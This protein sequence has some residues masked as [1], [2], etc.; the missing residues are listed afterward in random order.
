MVELFKNYD[1]LEDV[2]LEYALTAVTKLT[3]VRKK[4]IK[5]RVAY[6]G[7]DIAPQYKLES[8][9]DEQK[10]YSCERALR[11]PF[12]PKGYIKRNFFVKDAL[13]LDFFRFFIVRGAKSAFS[14]SLSFLKTTDVKV[15][16][17]SSFLSLRKKKIV[18][19]TRPLW[20]E[21][22]GATLRTQ[23]IRRVR[24]K[25]PPQQK[26]SDPVYTLNER[27]ATNSFSETL[28][29]LENRDY[30]QISESFRNFYLGSRWEEYKSFPIEIPRLLAL[31]S[32]KPV[33]FKILDKKFSSK[34]EKTGKLLVSTLIQYHSLFFS[35]NK[36]A[37][38][39]AIASLVKTKNIRAFR[40]DLKFFRIFDKDLLNYQKG[41]KKALNFKISP[42][43]LTKFYSSRK[44]AKLRRIGLI[45]AYKKNYD[46]LFQGNR[47]FNNLGNPSKQ[48]LLFFTR[49]GAP[50]KANVIPRDLGIYYKEAPYYMN[51]CL[52]RY[53]IRMHR[54]AR[55]Y[56][57]FQLFRGRLYFLQPWV[58]QFNPS[59]VLYSAIVSL[60]S[61]KLALKKLFRRNTLLF[62]SFGFFFARKK[63][64][65]LFLDYYFYPKKSFFWKNYKI[66]LYNKFRLFRRFRNWSPKRS[67]RL[68]YRTLS[69]KGTTQLL[70]LNYLDFK[71]KIFKH[72]EPTRIFIR[73]LSKINKSWVFRDFSLSDKW[74]FQSEEIS[75]ITEVF[76]KK[77]FGNYKPSFRFQNWR[78][79]LNDRIS[80]L[81][82]N[83]SGES[84]I[85][86]SSTSDYKTSKKVWVR[87]DRW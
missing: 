66:P 13:F 71:K 33:N 14:S 51:Q 59:V 37:C 84:L 75:K 52:V 77:N 44:K 9:L 60:E 17:T 55:P 24:I 79:P 1:K 15:L 78:K 26:S 48:S 76:L 36:T 7:Y 10:R 70:I 64:V 42:F 85:H 45:S 61:K 68:G 38:W 8:I 28:H 27:K 41:S 74:S 80:Q 87:K 23:G 49:R 53:Q 22:K 67:G 20:L 35:S 2:S 72:P 16:S 30:D 40:I 82:I 50:R 32:V 65:E 73:H 12:L 18:T 4:A 46:L 43:A 21:E 3:S 56:R 57:I 34:K 29:L 39:A 5:N 81:N 25:V 62:G 31:K 58:I 86:F 54:G 6:P 11:K 69:R 63:R 47:N 19:I 83:L